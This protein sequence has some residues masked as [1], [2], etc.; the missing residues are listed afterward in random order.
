MNWD[1]LGAIAELFGAIAVVATL[2]YLAKQM[3]RTNELAKA[4][5]LR[6]WQVEWNL[7]I[8]SL[9]SDRDIASVIQRGLR[10]YSS[11]DPEEKAV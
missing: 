2:A 1:A 9:G 3:R 7:I 4:Q 6:D 5:A 11:L 8:R 10:D